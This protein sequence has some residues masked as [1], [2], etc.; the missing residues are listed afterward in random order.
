M[1]L[2]PNLESAHDS[3]KNKNPISYSTKTQYSKKNLE[4]T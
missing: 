1:N 2:C 4:S 3:L